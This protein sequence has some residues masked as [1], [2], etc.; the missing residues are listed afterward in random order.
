MLDNK[1]IENSS[2]R[3]QDTILRYGR[4]PELSAL[5][6]E[7]ETDNIFFA[8]KI[9][10]REELSNFVTFCPYS[11]IPYFGNTQYSVSDPQYPQVAFF[12]I[13]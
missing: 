4:Q 9:D 13:F 6:F 10:I 11:N 12:R 8:I 7:I 3:I 1:T 2:E 5:G